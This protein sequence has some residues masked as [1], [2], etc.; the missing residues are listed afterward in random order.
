[1]AHEVRSLAAA[2]PVSAD[3]EETPAKSFVADV[4]AWLM[5]LTLHLGLLILLAAVTFA[6]PRN[7]EDLALV[8]DDLELPEEVD[9]LPQEFLSSDEA[10]EEYGAL[11]QGGFDSAQA[12][13]SVAAEQSL[14]IYEPED[15]T[16][17]GDRM[18]IEVDEPIFDGPEVSNDLPVQGMSHVG[19]TGAVGAIDRLT[20]EILDSVE[21]Q[22]TLVVWLFDQSGSMREERERVLAR[23]DTIY[24]QLGVIEAAKI[25]AFQ[26]HKDKPLLT[27]VVGFAATPTL[28]TK[29]ATDDVKQ[30]KAAVGSISDAETPVENV[31][32][33]IAWTADKFR[34]YRSSRQGARNVM[35]IVFTD[36][37][38]DDVAQLD[39]TVHLCRTLAMP[40]YVVGRPAPFGRR[41]AYVK[42][43]DPDPRFDQRPQQVPVSMGPESLMPER[44]RLQFFGSQRD[45]EMLD[46]GFGPYG[47][48]RLCY[49]T[50]G[51]Y[52]A[53]H[54]NRKTKGTVSRR[55]TSNLAAHFTVFFDPENMRRY[56]PDY[57]SSN[58][59]LEHVR[60][61]AA[62]R[63]LMEAA[64]LSWTTQMEDIRMRFVKRDEASLASSLTTAQRSAAIR[65]PQIDRICQLLLSGEEGR[66]SL[67]DARWQAG[68]DLALGRALATK[69][70]TD[71]YNTMLALAKQGMAFKKEKN[72]TWILRTGTEYANSSL[73]KTAAQATELL[74][75]VKTEHEGTPWAYLADR[76]LRAPLGWK[77][78][79]S[80]TF[81]PDPRQVANNNNNGRPR[82]PRNPTPRQRPP[83]RDPPP[84]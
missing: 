39:E 61:N 8:Y 16:D 64:E 56:Q 59:Y 25:P 38:G 41:Q 43:V 76:E 27:A 57:V 65:K 5:S 58:E 19:T 52:F 71:G 74:E 31:F 67:K 79:E 77:W 78:T 13:A 84:L 70:R 36:E 63:A 50:G 48:T 53:A 60:S 10:M 17:F 62:R 33:A 15:L 22:A 7:T 6:L 2:N 81:V 3:A 42:W 66:D 29:K 21:Q 80:Y 72:N 82:P 46:S 75:R 24:D 45:E 30:I 34:S 14:V 37:A 9:P 83:R 18:A 69:V 1:M 44:L 20:H 12:L 26:Q 23:F 51:L 40:V 68:Y 32:Q 47:L 28:L 55:E 54:P 4:G 73:E 49:E 11:S 35:I